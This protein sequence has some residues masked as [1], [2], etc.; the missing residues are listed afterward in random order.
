MNEAE[1]LLK[2]SAEDRKNIFQCY[3]RGREP[4]AKID[5]W[6][7]PGF[8]VYHKADRYGFIHDERLPQ[9][10]DPNEKRMKEIEMIRVNKWVKM[11]NHWD[12]KVTKDKLHKRI[13]KGRSFVNFSMNQLLIML[14]NL[15]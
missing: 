6:E 1:E 10:V 12:K 3:D 9:T 4:G 5:P 13:Y 11:L 15:V 7:D 2:R 14:L 8:E